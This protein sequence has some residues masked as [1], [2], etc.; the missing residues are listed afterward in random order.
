MRFNDLKGMII[1]GIVSLFVLLGTIPA[2]A[3]PIEIDF[4]IT[5]FSTQFSSTP[6]LQPPT[7]LVVG[8]ITYEA[9][10]V[11][12]DKIDS[13]ISIDL[14]IAGHTYSIGDVYFISPFSPNRQKIGGII[15]GIDILNAGTNDF[16]IDWYNNTLT[17]L[18]F[19]YTTTL[20]AGIWDANAYE[21]D[22]TQFSITTIPEPATLLLL[23]FGLFGL[24]G[25]RWKRRK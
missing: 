3:I 14:T 12:A 19:S 1:I 23:G 24:V 13:L 5:G 16:S 18:K 10:S 4:R 20:S 7:D 8:T 11:T 25:L 9:E 15:N 2:Q 17:P 6:P 21:N 22:F